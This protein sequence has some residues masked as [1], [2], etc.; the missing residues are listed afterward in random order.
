MLND[1]DLIKYKSNVFLRSISNLHESVALGR[2]LYE[3]MRKFLQYQ[4]TIALNL[5]VFISYS[6][7][8]YDLAVLAPS[9]ILWMNVVMDTMGAVIMCSGMP[10]REGKLHPT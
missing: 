8:R 9:S 6:V 4:L 1:R 2:N 5:A 10:H 3:N 7:I